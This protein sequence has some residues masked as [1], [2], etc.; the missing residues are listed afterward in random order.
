MRALHIPATIAALA[1]VAGTQAATQ[2]QWMP[3]TFSI[4]PMSTL[5]DWR[6]RWQASFGGVTQPQPEQVGWGPSQRVLDTSSLAQEIR[7]DGGQVGIGISGVYTG[8]LVHGGRTPEP[9][10]GGA[11]FAATVN[12]T[13]QPSLAKSPGVNGSA[14]SFEMPYAM[15]NMTVL[16]TG[17]G[18]AYFVDSISL[19]KRILTN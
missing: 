14:I 4:D 5:V 18:A 12:G 11:T 8:V 13:D 3:I 15:S 17:D 2:P 1:L 10:N 7:D 9:V 6:Y 16:P 19:G